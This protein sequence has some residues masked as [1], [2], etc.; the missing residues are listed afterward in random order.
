MSSPE[1][2]KWRDLGLR[3]LSAAVLIPVVLAA[4]W[5]GGVWFTL[6]V[7]VLGV[8]IAYEWTDIVHARSPAQ[9]SLHAAAAVSGAL[10]AAQASILAAIIVLAGLAAVGA[11]LEWGRRGLSPWGFLGIPYI[12][13]PAI[14]LVVLRAD[15]TFGMKVI[16]WLLVV[17]WA[18]D[19]S[20]YF[21]GRLIGGPRLAP[22]ISPKKTWAGAIGALLGSAFAGALAAYT[23]IGVFWAPALLAIV[24]SSVAQAGDLFKSALKRKYRLKD[25]GT[26]I[27]GHGGIIDRVD[28]VVAA[29]IAAAFIGVMHA[30]SGAA[31]EG[32]LVW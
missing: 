15:P 10:L 14:A 18:S 8:A 12:G 7:A 32:L 1:T 16:F 6:L 19:S 31:G 3:T 5:A 25:S 22:V 24:L 30:G 27:P 20:A 17:V 26:L 11:V 29:A 23:L 4:A 2:A 9:F 28:G 13:L 21:L